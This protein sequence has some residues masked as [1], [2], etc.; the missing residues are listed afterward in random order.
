MCRSLLHLHLLED[1]LHEQPDG[2]EDDCSAERFEHLAAHLPLLPVFDYHHYEA[3]EV[4]AEN[5]PLVIS[6]DKFWMSW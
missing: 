2:V 1:T 4:C 3:P 5:E 6:I